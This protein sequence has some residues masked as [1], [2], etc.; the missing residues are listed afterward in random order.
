MLLKGNQAN[1]KQTGDN[2]WFARCS[3]SLRFSNQ[4][5]KRTKPKTQPAGGKFGIWVCFKNPFERFPIHTYRICLPAA[6]FA[7]RGLYLLCAR[8]KQTF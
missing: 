2:V 4:S 6:I 5:D 7:T 8:I 1:V 3:L